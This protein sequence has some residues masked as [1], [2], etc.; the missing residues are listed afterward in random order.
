MRIVSVCRRGP[1]QSPRAVCGASRRAPRS[2]WAS[3]VVF[4]ISF[5]FFKVILS[6]I[7]LYHVSFISASVSERMG[8]FYVFRYLTF[9]TFV[10]FFLFGANG[11]YTTVLGGISANASERVGKTQHAYFLF[12]FFFVLLF[13]YYL[14]YFIFVFCLWA[15]CDI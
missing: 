8:N 10:R 15:I 12:S 14:F 2:E 9:F 5:F 6:F 11:Q 4:N 7:F 3:F 13:S 1:S